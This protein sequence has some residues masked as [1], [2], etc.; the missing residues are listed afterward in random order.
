MGKGR[1]NEMNQDHITTV[2]IGVPA[3]N[4]EA[5]IKNVLLSILAQKQENFAVEKILVVSDGSTDR[6]VEAVKAINSRLVQLIANSERRGQNFSQNL[7]FLQSRSDIVVLLEADTLPAGKDFLVNL[8]K[9]LLAN[10]NIA[11]A[12]G[13][14]ESVAPQTYFGTII[15][16]QS[17]IYDWFSINDPEVRSRLCSGRGGRAFTKKIYDQ[18]RWPAA[19]PEDTYALLWC[20]QNGF[21]TVFV[22]SAKCIYHCVE[23]YTDFL[24]VRE[25]EKSGVWSLRRY[26]PEGDIRAIYYR[27]F[28]MNLRMTLTFLAS[29]PIKFFLYSF[30]KFRASIKLSRDFNDFWPTSETTKRI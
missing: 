30:L 19:V 16:V 10:R 21:E 8:L 9:P 2:T 24:K 7:I 23:S 14:F 4:E 11:H 17:D 20:R 22:P 12:Q 29:D 6:T 25:K 18:L 5:N 26:F 1:F 28:W 27:S 15:K 13:N 3:Y